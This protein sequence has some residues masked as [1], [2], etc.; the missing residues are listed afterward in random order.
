VDPPLTTTG[1]IHYDQIGRYFSM[2]AK[3]S[4]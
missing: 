2:A 4:F 3:I 1:Q